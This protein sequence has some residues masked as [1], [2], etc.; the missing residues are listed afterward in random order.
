MSERKGQGFYNRLCKRISKDDMVTHE[1]VTQRLFYMSD[2]E[3]DEILDNVI[4]DNKNL[5]Q[6][7]NTS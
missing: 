3:F 1:Q 7:E 5:N 2:K 4:K 6:M